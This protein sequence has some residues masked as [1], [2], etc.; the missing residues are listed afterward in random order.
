MGLREVSPSF[1]KSPEETVRDA[2]SEYYKRTLDL[3]KNYSSQGHMEVEYLYENIEYPRICDIKIPREFIPL[4]DRYIKRKK[5]GVKTIIPSNWEIFDNPDSNLGA[6]SE[7]FKKYEKWSE[8]TYANWTWY[9]QN[10]PNPNSQILHGRKEFVT[11]NDQESITFFF[12]PEDKLTGF[13]MNKEM[14]LSLKLPHHLNHVRPLTNTAIFKNGV[15]VDLSHDEPNGTLFTDLRGPKEEIY[16]WWVND[17]ET[18]SGGGPGTK[19]NWQKYLETIDEGYPVVS[20]RTFKSVL[21]TKKAAIDNLERW[22]NYIY[23]KHPQ[24]FHF[25]LDPFKGELGYC[26]FGKFGR[27]VSKNPNTHRDLSA[28]ETREMIFKFIPNLP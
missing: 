22:Q 27:F 28:E 15:L 24:R 6:S 19:E 1:P 4:L 10:T 14:P 9:I 26:G 5:A 23:Y 17:I 16:P 12:T 21:Q 25:K 3:W 8:E 2:C 18:S 13:L 7:L 20:G 11:T